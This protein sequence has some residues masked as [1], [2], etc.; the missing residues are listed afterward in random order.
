MLSKEAILR[1]FQK[2]PEKHWGAELFRERGF[3]RKQCVSCGKFFWTADADR[4]TCADSKCEQY[5]F[6]GNTITKGTWDYAETWRLFEK[7][8]V[9]EGHESIPR[10]PVIDRIRPDLYFTIASIQVFQRIDSGNMAFVYPA[11]PLII[12]QPCLRFVDIPS[13]GMSGRHLTSFVMPGQHAFGYPKEGY[14]RDR[15]IELNYGFL[16]GVMGIPESEIIYAEDIWMM[17]GAFGPSIEAFSMGLEIVNHVFMQFQQGDSGIT[18]LPIKVNDTGWG[19]ERLV[20]FSNGT[21]TMYDC[22]FGN[23]VEKMKKDYGVRADPSVFSKYSRHAGAF[24]MADTKDASSL[25]ERI[26]KSIGIDTKELRASIEPVAAIYAICDHVR[27]LLFAVTDG[28]IPS[29]VGGGYN[30]RV[31][32]RRALAFMEEYNMDFDLASIAEGHAAFL[33]P[34]F[35]ELSQGM[36]TF[37]EIIEAEKTKH[38][39][40]QENAKKIVAKMLSAKEEITEEKLVQLYESHGITPELIS[41]SAGIEIPPGTYKRITERHETA[42]VE[43][44]KEEIDVSGFSPTELLFYR[45]EGANKFEA[46]VIGVG[47]NYVILDRTCFYPEGG[48]Q[49]ADHGLINGKRVYAVSKIG[50]VVVH[51]AENAGFTVGQ[52]ITGVIDWERRK[53]LLQHHTA[54]HILGAATRKVLGSHIF[55]AG[56]HKS[57]DKAHLDITHYKALSMEEIERIEEEASRIVKSSLRIKKHFMD[58]SEAEKK[59]GTRIYQ[60]GFVP[61]RQVRIVE[62][63]NEDVQ[64]CGGTHAESTRDA[65]RIVVVSSE[66]IQDGVD[67]ITI[68]AG[69]QAEKYAEEGMKT[70]SRILESIRSLPSISISKEYLRS[71]SAENA[72]TELRNSA[73]VFSVSQGQLEST[74]DRFVREIL[75]NQKEILSLSA[76]TNTGIRGDAKWEAGDLRSACKIIFDI[77]KSQA[78]TTESLRKDY[79]RIQSEEL[80]KKAKDGTVFEIVQVDRRWMIDIAASILE[81]G[82]GLTVVL[83]NISGEIVCMSR[84]K[85]MRSLIKEITSKAGGTGGGTKSL[86]QGKTDLSKLRKVFWK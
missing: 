5:R 84:T 81:N 49:E 53:Q 26:A 61:G 3:A 68:K 67:R 62:I 34:V 86:A 24:D 20:W 6:I 7:Y 70:A 79:A 74:I 30:L 32:L 60:G 50:N 57:F 72:Y 9:K 39:S 78:K 35:P 69:A 15:C 18:E 65:G 75:A 37:Q 80:I 52:K 83:A 54:I 31:I 22:I 10:Y 59:Y 47:S 11:N 2:E 36:E 38:R 17:P 12:P 82:P 25:Q 29:N 40:A 27:T 16:H 19:H 1:E 58:R 21:Q 64:A 33:R 63:G 44:K 28:G 41:K 56:T 85:D 73:D 55:Q 14:F 4:K 66:R 13:V 48:G 77:W 76:K 23:V 71:L 42:D 8:F 45:D 43:K 46:E 51:Y